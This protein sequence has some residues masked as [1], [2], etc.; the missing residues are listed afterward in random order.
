M[1]ARFAVLNEEKK[2]L[3]RKEKELERQQKIE[4]IKAAPVPTNVGK[5]AD[6][7][8]D[9]DGRIRAQA[10]HPRHLC[11]SD[12]LGGSLDGDWEQ[13]EEP[14]KVE[15]PQ[16]PSSGKNKKDRRLLK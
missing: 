14:P 16:A 11:R 4:E 10:M 6:A 5:W 3:R 13:R 12:P 2:I 15:A 9:E 1:A 8:D 7:S